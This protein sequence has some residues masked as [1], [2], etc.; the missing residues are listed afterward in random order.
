MKT[1]QKL[2]FLLLI[3]LM[4]VISACSNNG[5]SIENGDT[6]N[7]VNESSGQSNK[8]NQ[9]E[10]N[11]NSGKTETVKIKFWHAYGE[12]EDK[13][14]QEEVLP[15]FHDQF[16]GIE[17]EATRMPT[18]NLEQQVIT[19][20]AGGTPPDLM[21]MDIVWVPR[22]A[23]LGA[24]MPV[25][26][27]E[28]FS[29]IAENSFQGPLSSNLF[30]GEHYGIP[31][32]TNTK[33]AIYNKALLEEAGASEPPKT[34]DELAELA[35]VIKE[36]DK[37]GITIGGVDT[38]NFSGWF[39][40]LGG[41]YTNDDYTKADGFLNNSQSVQALET[42]L[43]WHEEGLLAPPILAGQPGTWE[44]LR[45]EGDNPPQYMM[46]EDGPWF[47][48]I[49]GD[50]VKDTTIP[51]LLPAGPDG[52]SHSIVG[53]QDLVLFKGADHP[54]EAWTFA[55]FLHSE[56]VQTLMAVKTGAIPANK[57]AAR[58]DQLKDIH[59]FDEYVNQLETA[60]PRTPSHKWNE[61][62]EQLQLSF[63]KAVRGTLS[64]QEA[65]D[66]AAASVD[67]ILMEAQEEIDAL[68]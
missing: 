11:Q 23:K 4:L 67:A 15:M 37:Y 49:L 22:F 5:S 24:L 32:D 66:E 10:K 30:N 51:A 57:N 68:K 48:S 54:E 27:M 35:R 56:E 7:N 58:S 38:W 29:Q 12:G 63:E 59:Y 61:I 40:T 39:W 52:T 60:F 19:A 44:G 18:E 26:D 43:S 9:T 31:L 28:N 36:K 16:P 8:D 2:G 62:S 6:D 25:D 55:Q 41:R 45:G 1:F 64:P 17:V 13:V 34:M 20:A 14:L 21:R 50:S 53:G 3:G 33:V 42:I 47:F 65:L 46:I